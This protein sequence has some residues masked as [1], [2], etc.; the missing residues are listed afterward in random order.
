[1]SPNEEKRL[2][3]KPTLWKQAVG[4]TLGFIVGS[5]IAFWL[6][7]PNLSIEMLVFA[8]ML[9]IGIAV[10]FLMVMDMY[11]VTTVEADT[12]V[13]GPAGELVKYFPK[14]IRVW[15]DR[16]EKYIANRVVEHYSAEPVEIKMVYKPEGRQPNVEEVHYTV[17]FQPFDTPE[18]FAW[19][20]RHFGCSSVSEVNEQA[21]WIERS[22]LT[23][24][25]ERH[26]KE[27]EFSQLTNPCNKMQQSVFKATVTAFLMPHD[28][29]THFTTVDASFDLQ[30][31]P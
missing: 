3:E 20:C 8:T 4:L 1:M 2:L 7:A 23:D 12:I 15:N 11:T 30:P 22:L 29:K 5:C 31:Q 21:A 6:K 26:P 27:F 19:C 28:E 18:S 24:L 10:V 14:A 16:W 9:W 17:T 13:I 25:N